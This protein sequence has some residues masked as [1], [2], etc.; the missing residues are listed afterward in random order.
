[1]AVQT[2]AAPE[3]SQSV[4]SQR[5]DKISMTQASHPEKNEQDLKQWS[6]EQTALEAVEA[7]LAN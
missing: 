1:M 4:N 3:P 6:R 7:F 2:V 5:G